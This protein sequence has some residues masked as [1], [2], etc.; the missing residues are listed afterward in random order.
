M[1]T[2]V[3][4]IDGKMTVQIDDLMLKMNVRLSVLG[5][6]MQQQQFQQQHQQQQF[7]SPPYYER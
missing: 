4:G 5:Q 1:Q 3:D 7:T 2:L 6:Q